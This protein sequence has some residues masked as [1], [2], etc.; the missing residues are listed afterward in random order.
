M[1]FSGQ[2]LNICEKQV[3]E[4]NGHLI[5]LTTAVHIQ[6]SH[7]SSLSLHQNLLKSLCSPKQ[8]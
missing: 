3:S 8:K 1:L 5:W 7:M 4:V 2:F 6:F